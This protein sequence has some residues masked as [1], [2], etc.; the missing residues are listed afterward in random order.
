MVIEE[1]LDLEERLLATDEARECG[2]QVVSSG[3]VILKY[4]GHIDSQLFSHQPD[5]SKMDRPTRFD[6]L[7]SPFRERTGSLLDPPSHIL[8]S[9]APGPAEALDLLTIRQD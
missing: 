5:A 7:K 3:D 6:V 2:W 1:V 9:P 4:A 8:L